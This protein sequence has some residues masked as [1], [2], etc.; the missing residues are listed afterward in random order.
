M[1]MHYLYISEQDGRDLQVQ[2]LGMEGQGY[3]SLVS[4]HE[5]HIVSISRDRT[6]WSRI[7]FLGFKSRILA[8]WSAPLNGLSTEG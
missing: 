8:D 4:E 6:M 7:A 3:Y 2:V 1:V 5:D